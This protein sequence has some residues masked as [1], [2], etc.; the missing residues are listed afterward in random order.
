MKNLLVLTDFSP[1]A[2]YAAEYGYHLASKLS[3]NI[4]LCNVINTPS[5]LPQMDYVSWPME[6]EE[7][8][9]SISNSELSGLKRHLESQHLQGSSPVIQSINYT[10]N[11]EEVLTNTVES[12]YIDLIVMGTHEDSILRN[13]LLPNHCQQMI[14][15]T[16]VP[17]LI[18]PPKA[19]QLNVPRI[20][21]ATDLKKISLDL[22]HIFKLVEFAQALKAD[23]V[24]THISDGPLSAQLKK[25]H[26]RLIVEISNKADY[27]HIYYK[28][29]ENT[30]AAN[31]LEWICKHEQINILAVVPRQHTF[32]DNLIKGSLTQNMAKHLSIPLLVFPAQ[33]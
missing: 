16:T 3:R 21:F 4:V 2:T 8:L 30:N 5:E 1:N 18:V 17:I 25:E 10:G 27:P 24:I 29:L 13:L 32:L 9:G 23:I 22:E 20:A 12:H 33:S 26:E 6:C 28:I 15:H 31:G 11:V 19:A 7:D 14:K